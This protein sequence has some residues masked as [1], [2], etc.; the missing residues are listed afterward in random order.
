MRFVE[1]DRGVVRQHRAIIAV[2][3]TQVGEEEMVIDDD[4]VGFLRATAHA[5]DE[6]GIVVR[7]LLS[8]TRLRTRV[9]VSPE[10]ERLREIRQ[11]GAIAGLAFTRPVTDLFEVID[12]IESFE[13]GRRLSACES[14]EA[15]IVAATL[16]VGRGKWFGQDALEKRNVLLHQLF[17]KVLRAGRND[18][19]AITAECSRNSGNE[20]GKRFSGARPGLDNE[21]SFFL[22]RADQ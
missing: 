10:R 21:V 1:Y 22:E 9:D 20:V 8:E 4:D 2:A 6:A 18:D 16:H 3:Q 13:H 5:R 15:K 17:L 14:V 12:F 7:T 11:L 19:T